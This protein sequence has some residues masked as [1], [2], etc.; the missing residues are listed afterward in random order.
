ML[1]SEDRYPYLVQPDAGFADRLEEELLRRLHHPVDTT[2][3]DRVDRS[4]RPSGLQQERN[5]RVRRGSPAGRKRSV[6]AL[7]IAASILAVVTVG[8]LT[9]W[10]F[11]AKQNAAAAVRRAVE[12]QEEIDSYEARQTTTYPDG[13]TEDATGRVEGNDAE[14][15]GVIEYPDGRT[16]SLKITEVGELI[17]SSFNG[18]NIVS[19]QA[20]D[21]T[22][23]P[24]IAE[25]SRALQGVLENSDVTPAGNEVIAGS[26]ATRYEIELND[27]ARVA[28]ADPV[29]GF[30]PERME[31]LTIWIADDYPRQ[32]EWLLDD[33]EHTVLTF[34]SI[35]DDL[36]IVAPTGDYTFD[37]EPEIFNP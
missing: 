7:G 30:D 13:R 3:G 10:Q 26:E 20:P 15:D 1:M 35:G 8:I 36:T 33:G 34:A 24:S 29:L 22:I 6:V 37:P 4:A 19:P 28:L 27:R 21:E 17:Y 5:G 31:R 12:R 9:V 16:E 23:Q 14:V 18:E 32:L 25:L 2:E 11:P